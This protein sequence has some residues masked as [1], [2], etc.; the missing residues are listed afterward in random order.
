MSKEQLN[1]NLIVIACGGTQS[2]FGIA[3]KAK[4]RLY[5]DGEDDPSGLKTMAELKEEYDSDEI[6]G[7]EVVVKRGE[8]VIELP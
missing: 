2:G 6:A 7:M 4:C 3:K 5:W 1:Q 8:F